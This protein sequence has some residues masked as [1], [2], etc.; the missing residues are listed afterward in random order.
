MDF[1]RIYAYR[2]KDVDQRQRAAVWQAIAPYLWRRMDSPRAVLDPA[3]GRGEFINAVPA[4]ERWAVDQTDMRADLDAGVRFVRSDILQADLPAG[5][6][7]AVFVSNFLEHLPSPEAV[8]QFLNKMRGVLRPGGRIA[9]MGPN[10]R[11]CAREYFDC[12]DHILALT[13]VAV[14]EHLYG[15]G[16]E[17]AVSHPRFLPYS[18]RQRLPPSPW[19]VRNYLRMPWAWRL[20][21]KQFLVIARR[22]ER[23]AAGR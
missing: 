23:D 11:Y 16:L 8:F 22:P 15:A 18:F 7:D 2:F 9:V 1:D 5:H 14:E 19:L 10:F 12:A 3:A 17:V 21:G 20:L 6:F 13:H 4:P